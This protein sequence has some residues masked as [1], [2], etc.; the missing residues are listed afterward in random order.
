M[1]PVLKV[2]PSRDIL[3]QN[4]YHL[5]VFKFSGSIISHGIKSPY[6]MYPLILAFGGFLRSGKKY[7]IPVYS[8]L[9]TT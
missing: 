3:P 1:A 5:I 8:V 2:E 6:L 4:N 9:Y 7:M